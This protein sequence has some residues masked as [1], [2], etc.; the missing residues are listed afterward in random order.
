[1]RTNL[2]A[3]RNIT[4]LFT[5]LSFA[6]LA[7]GQEVQKNSS[8]DNEI[9]I[10]VQPTRVPV[11]FHVGA[12]KR[13]DG[14]LEEIASKKKI[15]L[16]D[17]YGKDG[18]VVFDVTAVELAAAEFNNKKSYVDIVGDNS[19]LKKDKDRT[20]WLAI[21]DI[22]RAQFAERQKTQPDDLEQRVADLV[23]QKDVDYSML[24]EVPKDQYSP[25]NIS[26][27]MAYMQ[28][29]FKKSYNVNIAFDYKIVDGSG[30]SAYTAFKLGKDGVPE[31]IAD[32]RSCPG[33]DAAIFKD[34]KKQPGFNRKQIRKW[35]RAFARE[36]RQ[37]Q[38]G[39][40]IGQHGS[41]NFKNHIG[42]QNRAVRQKEKV[43]HYTLG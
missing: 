19:G 4:A 3:I 7:V 9:G 6:K 15:E 2:K 26:A 30:S 18:E 25:D 33:A 43:A 31:K 29:A 23:K 20:Y 21:A 38:L 37:Q 11:V 16:D 34:L 14:S 5:V 32:Q 8:N 13:G 17:D 40:N 35:K 28:N 24:I 1:M 12:D 27:E 41:Y 39:A 22:R 10:A 36:L 42:H